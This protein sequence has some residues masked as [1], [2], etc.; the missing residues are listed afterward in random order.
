VPGRR[1]ASHKFLRLRQPVDELDETHLVPGQLYEFPFSFLVPESISPQKCDHS[2]KDAEVEQ[3]HT[4]LPPTFESQTSRFWQ[5]TSGGWAPKACRISYKIR[6][7]ISEKSQAT[8]TPRNK[9]CD[10]FRSLRIMPAAKTVKCPD[11]PTHYLAHG[12][13][14]ECRSMGRMLGN[15]QVAAE[16]PRPIQISSTSAGLNNISTSAV[17]LHLTFDSTTNSPP[18]QLSKLRSKL[19]VATYYGTSPWEDYPTTEDME[20]SNTDREACI[21]TTPLQSLDLTSTEW[22]KLPTFYS[23]TKDVTD[24]ASVSSSGTSSQPSYNLSVTVPV[25]L[26]EEQALVP[27]FHS[28]LVSRTY[29]IALTLSYHVPSAIRKSTTNLR[30]P[31]EVIFGSKQS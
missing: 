27:T 26:P 14:S 20:C 31:L 28:C 12:R 4:Q 24:S 3:A 22:E 25:N 30:I 9:L 10:V 8:S 29:T 2:T 19:E 18:P 5:S 21:T 15:L 23:V 13:Q 16:E 6:V 7:A 17:Q 11:Y 1:K